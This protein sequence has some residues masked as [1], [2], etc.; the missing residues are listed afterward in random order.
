MDKTG[1]GFSSYIVK[2]G[3]AL[4]HVHTEKYGP[5]AFNDSGRGFRRCDPIYD[6]DGSVIPSYYAAFSDLVALHE[7]IIRFNR[8]NTPEL[9]WRPETTE[10]IKRKE[11]TMLCQFHS[12]GQLQLID[13]ESIKDHSGDNP[14]ETLLRAGES[15]YP[16]L[17]T[18]TEFLAQNYPQFDGFI[19]HS[20]QRGQ[21]GERA[22]MLFGNKVTSSQLSVV[23]SSPINSPA[24][25]DRLRDAA[26]VAGCKVPQ[27]L[28]KP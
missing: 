9:S 6:I 21:I 25:L 5:V 18:F 3:A 24:N 1:I 12:T 13:L 16:K 20:Y 8:S 22:L 4:Y 2:P 14:I 15:S 10:Q 7:T 11:V 17:H 23:D 28:L 27:W 19:W 26:A